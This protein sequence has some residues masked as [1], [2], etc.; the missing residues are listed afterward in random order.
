MIASLGHIVAFIMYQDVPSFCLGSSYHSGPHYYL[1]SYGHTWFR[2][3][4]VS[5][6]VWWLHHIWY[7]LYKFGCVTLIHVAQQASGGGW[8][9]GGGGVVDCISRPG[10]AGRVPFYGSRFPTVH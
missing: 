6:R 1:Q 9:G 7:R 10:C 2:L 8:T 4:I 5:D 3:I